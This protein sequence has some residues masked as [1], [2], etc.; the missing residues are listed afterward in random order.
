[1]L[2][3]RDVKDVVMFDTYEDFVNKKGRNVGK[4]NGF[5][6][7]MGTNYLKVDQGNTEVD[8][9]KSWG[10][11]IDSSLFRVAKIPL[12]V[13]SA[14]KIVYYESG[15]AHLRMLL[16]DDGSGWISTSQT[17]CYFSNTLTSKVYKYNGLG[18][19]KKV[20]PESAELIEC[21]RNGFKSTGSYKQEVYNTR[22]C[23]K[24]N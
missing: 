8:F 24:Q 16:D 19:I 12:L 6:F 23:M 15:V 18:K 21:I 1:M 7:G 11:T 10:F 9:D 22:K 14:G 13:Y 17:F 20:N 2:S 5:A 3:Q 4:F